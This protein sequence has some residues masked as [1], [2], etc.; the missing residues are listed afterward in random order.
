MTVAPPELNI[1][2]GLGGAVRVDR[3]FVGATHDAVTEIPFVHLQVVTA[4]GETHD[5]GVTVELAQ[6]VAD[7]LRVAIDA[8]DPNP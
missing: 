7:L 2:D 4:S 5:L 1:P 8:L 3:V 6:G